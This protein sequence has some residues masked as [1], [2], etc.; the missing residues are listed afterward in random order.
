DPPTTPEAKFNYTDDVISTT[1]YTK[2]YFRAEYQK[3]WVLSLS[4]FIDRKLDRD[5]QVVVKIIPREKQLLRR[6]QAMKD[7]IEPDHASEE[8]ARMRG[9]ESEA[10][11]DMAELLGNKENYA[12]FR[13]FN[14]DFFEQFRKEPKNNTASGSST[15]PQG[16]NR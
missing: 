3:R 16:M 11:K 14:R 7:K 12:K 6:L 15:A 9:I 4:E 5:A 13:A 2:T 1:D 8:I 10:A